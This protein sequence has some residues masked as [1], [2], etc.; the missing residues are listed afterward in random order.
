[1]AAPRANEGDVVIVVECRCRGTEGNR[2]LVRASQRM[3]WFCPL[4]K[5]RGVDAGSFVLGPGGSVPHP[6]D[7]R[8]PDDLRLPA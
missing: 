5:S 3:G 2:Q 7:R 1:M 6:R 8:S 4:C